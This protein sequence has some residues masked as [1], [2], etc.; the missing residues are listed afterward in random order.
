MELLR[1]IAQRLAQGAVVVFLVVT[2]TFVLVRIAPGSPL[3]SLVESPYASPEAI[4]QMRRNFGLDRPMHVQYGRYLARLVQ[5][6]LGISIARHRPV[7]EVLAG[8][9]PHTLLLAVAGLLITFAAGVALGTVQALRARTALDRWLTG[10]TLTFYAMPV[11]WLGLML[12]LVFGQ[13][14]GWFPI[15]GAADPVTHAFRS[16][17][18]QMVD[19]LHHLALPALA[20]GLV[21]SA[22]VARYQRAALLDVLRQDFVRAARARGLPERTVITRHALRAAMLPTVT[23]AGL[24]V[25][26]LLSGTVLVE[27]VFAWPGM[28]RMAAEAIFQRDYPVVA[29]AALLA[30]VLVVVGNLI[31]DV[32]VRLLDPRTERHA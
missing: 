6:D 32:A 5:G 28:G 23:L 2:L 8:A 19:R 26:G 16:P 14:L 10:I 9:F 25:P 12:L 22:E 11:F 30:A 20:L 13:W 29:G 3:S 24:A 21:G 17:F 27:T 15:G 1:F 31:A 18:G 4:D 7:V